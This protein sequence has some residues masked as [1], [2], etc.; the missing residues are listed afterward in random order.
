MN[1]Q[2]AKRLVC[3][4]VARLIDNYL[5]V[6]AHATNNSDEKDADRERKAMEQL[7]D[8]LDRRSGR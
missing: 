3:W 7:R 1:Q 5:D 8:E 6:G 2:E 4:T